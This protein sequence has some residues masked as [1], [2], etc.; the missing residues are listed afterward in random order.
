MATA[1]LNQCAIIAG[2]SF[3]L[4]TGFTYDGHMLNYTSG[5]LLA[6]GLHNFS[7]PSKESLHLALLTLALDGNPFATIFVTAAPWNASM[8][9]SEG[10]A[11]C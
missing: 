2:V 5:T 9:A 8:S 11:L 7:A 3:D 6:G 1:I 10:R 4:N